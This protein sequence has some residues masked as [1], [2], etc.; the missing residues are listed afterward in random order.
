ME[1]WASVNETDIGAIHSGQ[2]VRFTVGAFPSETFEGRVAQIR[3]NASMVQSVVTY[4]VV[5]DVDNT[6]GKLLPYLTARLEFEVERRPG[7]L[8]VPNA[9]LRWRPAA[10]HLA[11]PPS[12][13]TAQPLHRNG[14]APRGEPARP[15]PGPGPD[16]EDD[17]R[18]EA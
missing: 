13:E 8:L 14:P 5:V 15:V 12:P 11:P 9:A 10:A 6:G 2:L 18:G 16:A 3:L 1:I 17:A 7:V 4:T